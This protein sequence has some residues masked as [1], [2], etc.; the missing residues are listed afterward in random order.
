MLRAFGLVESEIR[1]YL[2]AIENGASTVI[3]LAKHAKI[4]RQAA[5][6]AIEDLSNRGLMTHVLHGK[7]RLYS[8]EHPQRLLDYARRRS[9]DIENQTR[10]LERIIPKIELQMGGDRPVVK[11]F[12]GKE[13]IMAILEDMK[14]QQPK[15]IDE[16]T[17]LDA[18]YTVA[19]VEDLK[20]TRT[21]LK[22]I[23]TV[24]DGLYSGKASPKIAR[25]NRTAL[26]KEFSGFKSNL[27]VYGDR[28][29]MTSLEGVMYSVIIESKS[30]ARTLSVL[31]RLAYKYAREY[32]S[33]E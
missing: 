31:F 28:I 26:P 30:L 21:E 27:S 9:V 2:A 19:T 11:V 15:H 3:D 18:L 10:E 12:Q 16:I 1:T 20:P 24:I 7:K 25:V 23:G 32:F 5:Y 33:K 8:A 6:L 22:R 17:D 29:T 13:G 14:K 4:S